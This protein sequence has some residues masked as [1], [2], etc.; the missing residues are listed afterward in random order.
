MRRKFIKQKIFFLGLS[1]LILSPSKAQKPTPTNKKAALAAQKAIY[2]KQLCYL[3][4]KYIRHNAYKYRRPVFHYSASITKSVLPLIVTKKQILRAKVWE[5]VGIKTD[6]DPLTK[7]GS[8]MEWYRYN[9]PK[10]KEKSLDLLCRPKYNQGVCLF[11][12]FY[13]GQLDLEYMSESHAVQFTV[14]DAD[15]LQASI[16]AGRKS[17][18]PLI[19]PTQK[20]C[21]RIEI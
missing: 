4:D 18:R 3:R 20:E 6:I 15:A 13:K 17:N 8:L 19:F 1:A 12:V 7:K 16:F 11:R 21:N 10:D 2:D 9:T 14:K 5:F